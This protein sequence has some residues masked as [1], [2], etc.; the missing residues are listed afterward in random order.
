[1]DKTARD[2]IVRLEA[3][4]AE[5]DVEMGERSHEVEHLRSDLKVASSELEAVSAVYGERAVAVAELKERV[6]A[7]W[8]EKELECAALRQE[9]QDLRQQLQNEKE[10]YNQLHTVAQKL[11]MAFEVYLSYHNILIITTYESS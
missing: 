3:L 5:K 4:L 8:Q 10:H 1:M 6:E 11:R 7:A 9:I 2:R